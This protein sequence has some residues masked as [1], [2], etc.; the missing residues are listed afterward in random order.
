MGK[1]NAAAFF[2]FDGT[3]YKG[4]IAAD[5]LSYAL[6]N[7]QLKLGECMRLPGFFYYYMIDKLK[8]SDRY[9][10]NQKIYSQI[11]GW[12][13]G[14]LLSKSEDFAKKN[15]EKR[16]FPETLELL[17][18]HRK[19]GDKIVIVTSALKEIIYPVKKILKVDEIF[20]TEVG[21]KDGKYNGQIISLPVGDNRA[22]IIKKYCDENKLDIDS[23]S[24]YSDHYSDIAMLD[25]VGNPVAVHPDGKL[26]KHAL[27]NEWKIIP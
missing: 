22:K 5:F 16:I 21:I 8:I 14:P 26:K 9:K 15:V 23:C 13:A 12:D 11:S 25:I 2:D 20:G 19:K 17:D 6:F 7:R 27:K 1:T 4:V 10:I 24:A 18:L 3:L